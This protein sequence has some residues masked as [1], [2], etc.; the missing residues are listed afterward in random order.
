MLNLLYFFIKKLSTTEH[1]KGLPV[2]LKRRLRVSGWL[3]NLACDLYACKLQCA[4]DC[5]PY[6]WQIS[7]KV[8]KPFI[9]G[10]S[11]HE[12]IIN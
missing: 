5:V 2:L 9:R 3:L 11:T 1:F 12:K 4:L 7:S 10:H 6:I 8:K